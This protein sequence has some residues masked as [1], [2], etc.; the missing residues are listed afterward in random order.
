MAIDY[1][2]AGELNL[3][4][5]I[6]QTIDYWLVTQAVQWSLSDVLSIRTDPSYWRQ[7]YI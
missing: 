4:V 2:Y 7:R 6:E 5:C 1:D 3:I